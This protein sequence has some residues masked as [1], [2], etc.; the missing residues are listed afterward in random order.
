MSIGYTTASLY[1]RSAD[2]TIPFSGV[3]QKALQKD[4]KLSISGT[5][6]LATSINVNDDPLTALDPSVVF[7]AS[8]TMTG[9]CA[10]ALAKRVHSIS[11]S[12]SGAVLQNG[13]VTFFNASGKATGFVESTG[14]NAAVLYMR[15]YN[16]LPSAVTVIS[17]GFTIS[18][19]AV[20]SDA[21]VSGLFDSDLICVASSASIAR[22]APTLANYTAYTQS[23]DPLTYAGKD[24]RIAFDDLITLGD[25]ISSRNFVLKL[26][27]LYVDS[28]TTSTTQ[29]CEEVE[30]PAGLTVFGKVF[31]NV[32]QTVYVKASASSFPTFSDTDGQTRQLIFGGD[33]TALITAMTQT[34]GS[35]RYFHVPS[36]TVAES[37]TQAAQYGY[38][39]DAGSYAGEALIYNDG[40]AGAA[41]P[42][43]AAN[44]NDGFASGVTVPSLVIYGK[45]G[46]DI[47]Y[48]GDI[49][50]NGIASISARLYIEGGVLVG[51]PRTNKANVL[52]RDFTAIG[53]AYF[54]DSTDTEEFLVGGGVCVTSD[55]LPVFYPNGIVSTVTITESIVV[56]PIHAWSTA[57]TIQD[58]VTLSF[59]NYA[60]ATI[61][62]VT[63]GTVSYEPVQ[64]GINNSVLGDVFA[65]FL[66]IQSISGTSA[67]AAAG[68]PNSVDLFNV[69]DGRTIMD[70]LTI[71][72]T[73]VADM[74]L[75]NI[76]IL[77]RLDTSACDDLVLSISSDSSGSTTIDTLCLPTAAN[78]GTQFSINNRV[79]IN[80][81]IDARSAAMGDASNSWIDCA[82]DSLLSFNKLSMYITAGIPTVT[83][84]N[85]SRASVQ[86]GTLEILASATPAVL[87]LTSCPGLQIGTI[88]DASAM[89]RGLR[90]VNSSV[91]SGDFRNILA[92]T[93]TTFLVNFVNSSAKLKFSTPSSTSYVKINGLV[94][95]ELDVSGWTVHTDTT[96]TASCTFD[97]ASKLIVCAGSILDMS[98]IALTGT[99]PYSNITIGYVNPGT[100]NTTITVPADTNLI[101]QTCVRNTQLQNDSAKPVVVDLV[102]G[103]ATTSYTIKPRGRS[104]AQYKIIIGDVIY[105]KDMINANATTA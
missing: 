88:R 29:T 37:G 6:G 77:G 61:S 30:I 22:S 47:V 12:A 33:A 57:V 16:F 100:G 73:L 23:A 13:N 72:S 24:L 14:E 97:Y 41:Y 56:A 69:A 89:C 32:G 36:I 93:T 21:T 91:K 62:G 7:S 101:G 96:V 8:V 104:N 90:M 2:S 65:R 50:G 31:I 43:V 10:A 60:V 87:N 38:T 35:G 25:Q 68:I 63:S 83:A 105:R 103:A 51:R 95:S 44:N 99:K 42:F 55:F 86:I 59:T 98:K 39:P 81:T 74:Y 94:N 66:P 19:T 82:S 26:G 58:A 5:F 67:V 49:V 3:A 78:T 28:T 40:T 17:S 15:W 45:I 46:H 85:T 92:A 11:I 1:S 53:D 34:P 48:V 4:G 79:T 70:S 64:L 54:G 9:G 102:Y 52:F 75:S 80:S 84:V 76:N 71:E 27:S 18:F 20:I